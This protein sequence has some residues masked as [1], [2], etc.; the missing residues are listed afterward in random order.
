MS[1][2][3]A[4]ECTECGEFSPTDHIGPFGPVCD[5]CR[6]WEFLAGGQLLSIPSQHIEIKKEIQSATHQKRILVAQS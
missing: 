6:D 4:V 2:L 5:R 1:K 3:Q